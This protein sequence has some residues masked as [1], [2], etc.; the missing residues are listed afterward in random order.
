MSFGAAS[1]SGGIKRIVLEVEGV[2]ALC[3]GRIREYNQTVGRQKMRGRKD[4]HHK[5]FREV[6]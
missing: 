6:R 1:Y 5:G 2:K 3:S 4:G